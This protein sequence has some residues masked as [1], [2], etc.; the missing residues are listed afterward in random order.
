MSNVYC[1]KLSLMKKEQ[2]IG[3]LVFGLIISLG[4]FFANYPEYENESLVVKIAI[5]AVATLILGLLFGWLLGKFVNSK[6]VK[7]SSIPTNLYDETVELEA[8]SSYF[9]NK[10]GV[11]GK[12]Y[13]LQS[14]LIF[15][16]HKFNIQDVELVID[17]RDIAYVSRYKSIGIVNNGLKIDLRNNTSHKFIVNSAKEWYEALS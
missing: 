10:E 16:S 1:V 5:I 8:M 12:M 17:K 6:S 14:K 3:G 15:K 2:L 13:L 7:T 9:K 4:Y 11:G